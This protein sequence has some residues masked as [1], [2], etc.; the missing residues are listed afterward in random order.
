M[1]LSDVLSTSI[2][3][4]TPKGENPALEQ[5][6]LLSKPPFFFL[7]N[8]PGI[9]VGLKLETWGTLTKVYYSIRVK[10]MKRN[11]DEMI[12]ENLGVWW[13][14]GDVESNRDMFSLGIWID[15]CLMDGFRLRGRGCFFK[16]LI[17]ILILLVR[18]RRYGKWMGVWV[19]ILGFLK[20]IIIW[21][22]LTALD[23][24]GEWRWMFSSMRC[25]ERIYHV[26]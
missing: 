10:R 13:L 19:F 18:G 7:V 9:S 24:Y 8:W 20:N 6:R 1:F 3:L 16:I 26:N 4:L 22:W 17:L 23:S 2:H 5:S 14:N 25:W 11:G 15:W 21:D 12:Y